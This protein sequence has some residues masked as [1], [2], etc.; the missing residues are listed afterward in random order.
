LHLSHPLTWG[1]SWPELWSPPTGLGLAL[2]AWFGPRAA[3]L[4]ALDGLLVTLQAAALGWLPTPAAAS[5]GV[6]A[7]DAVLTALALQ[8]GWWAYRRAGGARGLGDPRSAILFLFLVPGLTAALSALGRALLFG[9]AGIPL[10]PA[11]LGAGATVAVLWLG[12]ALGLLILAPPLLVGGTPMVRG[13]GLLRHEA[14]D[15]AQGPEQEHGGPER[16]TR[17]DWVEVLG[18][19]AGAGAL[20]VL[21]AWLRGRKELDSWQLWAMPLLL[22][23]WASLRQGLR[24]GTLVASAAAAAPL[25][26][27][28]LRSYGLPFTLVLQGN[29]LAVCGTTLLVAVSAGWIRVLETRYRQ[30]VAH[31]PVVVYSARLAGGGKPGRSRVRGAAE[32]TLVSAASSALLGCPPEELLGPYERWLQRVHPDDREV[33]LAALGQ[34]ELQAEP[35]TCE[36]RLRK[37][38][39][40]RR[41]EKPGEGP[42]SLPPPSFPPPPS[43]RWVRDVLAPHRDEY[44]RLVGW[45]GVVT[46]ITEQRALAH[47]L[48]RTTS[49]LHALVANLPAGVFFVQGPH[50]RPILVN[51][52]ARQLLGRGEEAA[53]GLDRLSEVYHLFRPDGTPYPVEELPVVRALR[54]GSTTMCDD[55]VV[56]RPDGRRIPLITW[57]APVSLAAAGPGVESAAVWVLQDLTNR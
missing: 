28:P 44:G 18:L 34:L 12:Q 4:I 3:L 5:L 17:G 30:V 35:V 20:N 6:G 1:Q 37:E 45:E 36:Y 46:D 32:V 27:L 25:L 8:V 57:A 14:A 33:V 26:L 21:L 16:L 22:I 31:I 11:G 40:E 10:I 56:H 48:R 15:E 41:E 19:C 23:V 7:A 13:W 9:L 51:A 54:Q 38:E 29:L 39:G 55:V 52:R 47:D 49:M 42:A 50:G 2:I 53:A 43:E 24:G